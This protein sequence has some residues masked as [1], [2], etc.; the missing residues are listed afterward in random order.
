MSAFAEAVDSLERTT[1]Y[2]PEDPK[3][4]Y[5]LGLSLQSLG[6]HEQAVGAFDRTLALEAK[7]AK[8]YVGKGNSLQS[9]KRYEEAA[10]EIGRASCRKECRCGEWSY[11]CN[12]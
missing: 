10:N 7:K 9:L 2:A 12:E 8:V 5:L 11:N 6:R 4:W 3:G 1:R